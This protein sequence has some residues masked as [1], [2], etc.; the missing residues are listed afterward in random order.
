[1]PSAPSAPRAW[2]PLLGPCHSP[3]SLPAAPGPSHGLASSALAPRPGRAS[4][5]RARHLRES[6]CPRAHGVCSYH[7]PPPCLHLSPPCRCL[8]LECAASQSTLLTSSSLLLWQPWGPGSCSAGL[9]E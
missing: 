9:E 4:R 7:A 8:C 6:T 3:S 1:M 5:K 2:R